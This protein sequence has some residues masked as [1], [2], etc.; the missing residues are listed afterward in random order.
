MAQ[1]NG[2]FTGRTHASKAKARREAL[3]AAIHTANEGSDGELDQLRKLADRFIQAETKMLKAR[4]ARLLEEDSSEI[5][6]L[7]SKVEEVEA[8]DATAILLKFGYKKCLLNKTSNRAQ[9]PTPP[10]GH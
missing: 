3:L 9:T 10:G 5:Q 6:K 1:W 8:S 4:L 2:Q 7:Q